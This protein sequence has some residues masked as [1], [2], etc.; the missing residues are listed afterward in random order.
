MSTQIQVTQEGDRWVARFQFSHQTKDLVKAAG[1][2]FDGSRKVWWTKDPNVAAALSPEGRAKLEEET[3][4][5]AAASEKALAASRAVDADI[6]IPAPAGLSYLPYQRGGIAYAMARQNVLIGDEM[7]L[8][9]TIQA[10]GVINADAEARSVLVICPASLKLNW[11]RELRKWLTRPLRIV[12]A[13]GNFPPAELADIVIINYDILEKHRA[14]IDARGWDLLVVDECHYLKNPKA[15]RTKAVL[16]FKKNRVVEV[17]PIRARR[18]LMMTGTPICN[19]P[20]ELWPLVHSL[21]PQGLGANFMKFAR[22]Y[23][24]AHRGGFGWDFTGASHLD[25]L[26]IKLRAAIMVRRL[27][28]DVLTDLPPKRRQIIQIEATGALA[29]MVQ[30]ENAIQARHEEAIAAARAALELAKAESDEVYAAAARRLADETQVAFTEMSAAR[31][32]LAV[33]KAPLVAEHVA[34]L[35][36][37]IDKVVVM[38]H[39][40]EVIDILAQ[41]LP[42]SAIVDGRVAIEDRQKAVDRFQND[43]ACRVFIGGIRAAGVGLTLTAASTVVFAELDWTPGNVSQA[44]DRCHRLGQRNSVLIQHLVVDGSLD[45]RMASVLV[46]KQAVIDAAMDKTAEPEA[47]QTTAPTAEEPSTRDVRR[48]ALRAYGE[49]M[50]DAQIEAVRAGLSMLAGMDADHAR[51]QNAMGFNK[52]DGRIG[53]EL[54]ARAHLSRTQAALG[55]KLLLK[56]RRQLGDALADAIRGAQD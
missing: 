28:A 36:E 44:E 8:G 22:R 12:V 11:A 37:G 17:E 56:Y 50:T 13:N 30:A 6:D 27:K 35:L 26:Q 14:A 49:K 45:A 3:A 41:H 38:A 43:P 53:H 16:G 10:I 20:I 5:A 46:E 25:E 24:N 2:R 7:G 39:H 1:F 33:A 4:R 34:S 18:R 29:G 52:M 55:R 9:K 21:D 42:G 40:L 54:A 31:H 15:K 47:E 48:Q 19:R 23:C 51:V 32:D